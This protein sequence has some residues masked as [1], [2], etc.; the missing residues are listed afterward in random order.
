MK[1]IIRY[2]RILTAEDIIGAGMCVI[3]PQ[4]YMLCA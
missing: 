1:E 4:R 3:W 2:L